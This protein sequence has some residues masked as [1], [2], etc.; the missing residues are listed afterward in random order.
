M[1]NWIQSICWN[2]KEHNIID[3]GDVSDLTVPDVEGFKCWNCK[4]NNLFDEEGDAIETTEEQFDDGLPM[5]KR[6]T[7]Q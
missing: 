2:C 6:K 3:N 7:D 1:K 4:S 5:P